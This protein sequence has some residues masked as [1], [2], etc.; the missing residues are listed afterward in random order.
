MSL[1]PLFQTILD[2]SLDLDA[3]AFQPVAYGLI[4]LSMLKMFRAVNY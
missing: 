2:L 3:P 1:F 4:H